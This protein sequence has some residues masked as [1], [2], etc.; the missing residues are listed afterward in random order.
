MKSCC[1]IR[2]VLAKISFIGATQRFVTIGIA[3]GRGDPPPSP[4]RPWASPSLPGYEGDRCRY[5]ATHTERRYL[6]AI[7]RDDTR[8]ASSSTESERRSSISVACFE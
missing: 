1:E 5:E 3:L 6:W 8:W 7:D 4:V 2:S